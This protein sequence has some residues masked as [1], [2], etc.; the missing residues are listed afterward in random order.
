VSTMRTH[1][2]R[3]VAGEHSPG[4]ILI[5]QGLSIA[6]AIESILLLCEACE[7]AEL[8]NKICLVPSLVMYGF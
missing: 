3:F 1:F 5:P 2:E 7:E 4:L 6:G 8:E